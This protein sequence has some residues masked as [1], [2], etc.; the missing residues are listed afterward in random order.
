LAGL[1]LEKPETSQFRPF[2]MCNICE[3]TKLKKK[4]NNKFQYLERLQQPVLYF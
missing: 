3:T 4:I 1:W 2:A